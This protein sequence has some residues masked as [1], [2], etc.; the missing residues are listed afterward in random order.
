MII[1]IAP[2]TEL[3]KEQQKFASENHYIVDN[4]LK[5]R[6]LNRDKYYDMVIFG[7]LRAV[8][9]YF[10]RSELWIYNFSTIAQYAMKSDLY[11]HYRKLRRQKRKAVV[12]GLDEPVYNG[13][14]LTFEE[15]TAAPGS[16]SDHLD[17]EILWNEITSNLPGECVEVLRM[18]TEGYS[19]REIAKNR[20][21]R[22]ID[23][24]N[25]MKQIR[26]TTVNIRSKAINN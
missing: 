22:L 5:Y 3:T 11:N 14:G 24:D 12:V 2:S 7:F 15:V 25:M 21:V 4:F 10:N 19:D 17:A 16:V 8:K 20:G 1:N 26:E 23:V 6:R 9:N 18:R 13:N